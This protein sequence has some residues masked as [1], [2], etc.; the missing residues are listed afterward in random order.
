MLTYERIPC[1]RMAKSNRTIVLNKM[2]GQIMKEIRKI[3]MKTINKKVFVLALGMAMASLGCHGMERRERSQLHL[4]A[5]EGDLEEI[6]KLVENGADVNAKK[7]NGD[8]PL[9]LA[10]IYGYLEVVK[11]LVKK[12]AD[13]NAKGN[14]G[15]T[16]LHFAAM[17]G[18]LNV[19]KFLVEKKADVNAKDNC[20]YTPLHFAAV[21]GHLNMVTYLVLNGADVNA[22]DNC[23][24]APLRFAAEYGGHLEVVKFL[25]KKEADVNAKDHNG[26]TPLDVLA[27]KDPKKKAE[28]DE[29]YRQ[30]KYLIGYKSCNRYD[31]LKKTR[32][33]KKVF[34]DLV[35][36]IQE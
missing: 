11:Y 6:E 36:E 30:N 16:P 23:G 26:K 5:M 22:K 20:G 9:H 7:H 35:I 8:T 33:H 2:E 3:S 29:W 19:V 24:D 31:L 34:S 4:A 28:F 13:V 27:E 12:K 25:V 21:N 18:H 14:C 32:G 10:A 15:D 17:N 1:T